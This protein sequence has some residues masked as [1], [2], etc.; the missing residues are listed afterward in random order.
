M[1]QVFFAI[2]EYP[3]MQ[4]VSFFVKI[5]INFFISHSNNNS[6]L[7]LRKRISMFYTYYPFYVRNNINNNNMIFFFFSFEA[8][9]YIVISVINGARLGIV[10]KIRA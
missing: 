8:L 1:L 10:Q 3:F 4:I 5:Q 9:H 2:I 7:I 6:L